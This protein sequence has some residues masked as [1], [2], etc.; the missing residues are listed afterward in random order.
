MKL[1]NKKLMYIFALTIFACLGTL[2][3]VEE[4]SEVEEA[5]SGPEVTLSGGGAFVGRCWGHEE[6]RATNTR[7][8]G[9]LNQ[10]VCNERY[11]SIDS[12]G[13]IVRSCYVRN[14]YNRTCDYGLVANRAGRCVRRSHHF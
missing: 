1:K 9:G 8:C 5:I 11:L 14:A 2:G 13:Y 6:G 7:H 4:D 12:Q 10:R 3:C